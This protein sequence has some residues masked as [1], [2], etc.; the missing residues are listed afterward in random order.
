MSNDILTQR[1]KTHGS[2]S[3]VA[4]C[5]VDVDQVWRAQR[6]WDSLTPVQKIAMQE[7]SHKAARILCGNPA[8][9][10]HW[11]DIIGYCRLVL[12]ELG[13]EEGER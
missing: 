10:D 4:A 5:M 6:N 3:E 11:R 1:Q 13:E 9:R 7:I 2:F 12:R 8:E